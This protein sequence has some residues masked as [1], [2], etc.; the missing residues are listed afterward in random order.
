MQFDCKSLLEFFPLFRETITKGNYHKG[1]LQTQ[2]LSECQE[3]STIEATGLL[4]NI[5]SKLLL[6]RNKLWSI[7]MQQLYM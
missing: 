4:D 1:K 6:V 7:W 3:Q 2:P 5:A